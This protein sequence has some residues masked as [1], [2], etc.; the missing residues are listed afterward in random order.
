M[1]A[2]MYSLTM[3]TIKVILYAYLCPYARIR[4][5][6]TLFSHTSSICCQKVPTGSYSPN[7]YILTS[8]MILESCLR[9]LNLIQ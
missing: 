3:K 4:T 6:R 2:D 1:T 9:Q 8:T 5:Y 7:F